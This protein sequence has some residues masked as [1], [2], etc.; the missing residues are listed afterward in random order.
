MK[1]TYTT[2]LGGRSL[3]VE[4]G[5]L[6]RQANAACLVRYG[7]TVVLVTAGMA[8]DVR[9]GIDFFPLRVDVEERLYAAGRIPGS[10]FRREGRPTEKAIL[11]A[12][13]TDRSIRPLFPK[14]FRN[15]V[16]VVAT[17]LSYDD[18]HSAEVAGIIG[19]SVA[20]GV[21]EIPF[22]GPIAAV[23]VGL[24]DGQFTINPTKEESDRSTLELVV[25]GTRDAVIM[26]EAG[27][28]EISEEGILDAIYFGHQ[29]I[30]E[31][32]EFQEGLIA[33]IGVPKVEPVLYVVPEEIATAVRQRAVGD[34]GDA[35]NN[36]DKLAREAAVQEVKSRVLEELDSEYPDHA[37]DIAAVLDAIEKEVMRQGILQDNR[38]PDSRKSDEIRPLSSEVGLLPRTHGSGLFTRGQTQVLTVAALGAPGD[39]QMLDSLGHI[40]DFKRYMHHYNFPPYSVGEVRP[41]RAPGR[42]EIGHGAL[43]ERALL[44]VIPSDE[45]FP[46]TIRLVSEVLES[47]GSTSMASVCASTLSLMDAGV[48]ISEPVAGIAMGLIKEGDRFVVLSDIQGMEDFLGDMDFKVAGTR[49]GVTAIQMDIKIAGVE[50]A[51]LQQALEQAR[52]GRMF[53]MESMLATLPGPRSELS[54]YAPRIIV[55]QIDPE[56]IRDVIGPGGKTINKIIAATGVKIDIED[57]GRVYIAAE[58]PEGGQEARRMIEDLTRDVEVGEI[59]VGKVVRITN[60][61]AFVE[62]LPGKDGLV[63]ISELAE[64]RVPTVEDVVQMGDQILVKVKEIDDLGRVNLSRRMALRERADG[65]E[66]ETRN[67]GGSGTERVDRR[68]GDGRGD[69]RRGGNDRRGGHNR[70]RR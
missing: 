23:I 1:K 33:E 17:I 18:D 14:G 43:A 48:P 62:L 16:Q 32:I 60:F 45:A 40:E 58:T 15:E 39:R 9:E 11:S 65:E 44:P 52:R 68:G 8:R 5:Q 67:P 21:S 50:R 46:Y 41:L 64:G 12:R 29:A 37:R 36:P 42:R 34:L 2:S 54:P 27:A 51:V 31:N 70:P 22:G 10:F 55:L 30:K 24:V 19:A 26:V 25:A 53:I 6:A 56:K 61:G 66:L 57:D 38:R 28:R 35:I 20:L 47:N 69:N 7:D 4:L 49:N 59:Y 3:T 63:H 13:L